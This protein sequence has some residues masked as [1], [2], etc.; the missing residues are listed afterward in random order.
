MTLQ[1]TA[2]LGLTTK[3]TG[4]TCVVGKRGLV[5]VALLLELHVAEEHNGGHGAVDGVLLVVVDAHDVHRLD[6]LAVHLLVVR[7]RHRHR[8]VRQEPVVLDIVQ[9]ER[10]CNG[11]KT[12]S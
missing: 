2:T 1:L 8:A 4:R 7:A 3:K 11:D 12:T 5:G 6:E 9:Q 10:F